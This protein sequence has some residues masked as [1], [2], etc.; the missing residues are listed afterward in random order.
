[1]YKEAMVFDEAGMKPPKAS[2]TRW[3]SQKYPATKM[4]LFKWGISMRHLQSL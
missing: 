1:M 4:C 2:G 3:I